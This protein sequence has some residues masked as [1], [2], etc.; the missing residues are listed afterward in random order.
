MITSAFNSKTYYKS[1]S[2]RERLHRKNPRREE[3]PAT[4]QCELKPG[5]RF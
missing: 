3:Q 4:C 5:Y 2:G 1:A